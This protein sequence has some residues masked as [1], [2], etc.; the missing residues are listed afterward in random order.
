MII[1]SGLAAVKSLGVQV[2]IETQ[3]AAAAACT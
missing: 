3:H 2:S 1:I